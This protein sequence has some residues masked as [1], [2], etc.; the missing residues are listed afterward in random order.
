MRRLG[1][2]RVNGNGLSGVLIDSF[3]Y[4]SVLHFFKKI[5]TTHHMRL[6]MLQSESRY[7]RGGAVHVKGESFHKIK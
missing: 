2:Q 3:E 6:G 1:S 4:F 5:K 7:G